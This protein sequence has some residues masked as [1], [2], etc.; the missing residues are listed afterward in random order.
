MAHAIAIAALDEAASAA[1]SVTVEVVAVA[2]PFQTPLVL[3][4][5]ARGEQ[6]DELRSDAALLSARCARARVAAL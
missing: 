5:V 3:P 1:K 2:D 6:L 4:S